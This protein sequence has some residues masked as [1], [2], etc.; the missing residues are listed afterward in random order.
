[1]LWLWGDAMLTNL[2]KIGTTDLTKWEKTDLHNVNNEDVFEEWVDGNW[3][4]H[5]TVTRTR[6]SGTVVLSFAKETD[7]A[8]FIALLSAERTTDG[9]YPITVW[10]AGSAVTINAFLD[11]TTEDKFDVTAPIKHH[12][13]T[14]TITER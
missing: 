8:A 9:Y 2:F 1:M 3:I 14:V 6:V 7:Y 11:I 4:T 10:C 5:R 13:V 12:T